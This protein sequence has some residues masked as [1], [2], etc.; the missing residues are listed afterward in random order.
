MQVEDLKADKEVDGARK[1]L[2]PLLDEIINHVKPKK[3]DKT[4]PFAMLS[5]L[6]ADSFQ[7][8][9]VGKINQVLQS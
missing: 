7:R 3:L 2:N 1:N 9:L 6:Y 8:S 5:T 4:K